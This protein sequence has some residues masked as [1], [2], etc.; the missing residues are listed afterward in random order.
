[1]TLRDLTR[2][3]LY[4]LRRRSEKERKMHNQKGAGEWV[5]PKEFWEIAYSKGLKAGL[6]IPRP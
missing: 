5:I 4:N 2:R 3:Q 1:M 6:E